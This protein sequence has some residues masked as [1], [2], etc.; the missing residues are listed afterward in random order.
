MN[1]KKL[2]YGLVSLISVVA[3]AITLWIMISSIAKFYL[4]I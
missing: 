3:I 2:Y 4:Q 1:V